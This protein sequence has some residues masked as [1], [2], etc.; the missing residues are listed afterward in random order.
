[1]IFTFFSQKNDVVKHKNLSRIF[2]K[3]TQKFV[4]Y[5][6]L[7]VLNTFTLHKK[8]KRDM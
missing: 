5:C 1:M 2:M 6:Q 4:N 7:L 3:V 8:H